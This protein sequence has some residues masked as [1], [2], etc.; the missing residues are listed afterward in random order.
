MPRQIS[1]RT[2][3]GDESVA[4]SSDIRRN[5]ADICTEHPFCDFCAFLRLFRNSLLSRR[6][7][8]PP[9][10]TNWYPA[11]VLVEPALEREAAPEG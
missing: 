6:P 3:L 8:P 1:E 5:Y 4:G 2:V 7:F 9:L 10:D 11:I